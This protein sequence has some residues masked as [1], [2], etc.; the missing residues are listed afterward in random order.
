MIKA[1]LLT[2]TEWVLPGLD[3]VHLVTHP[4]AHSWLVPCPSHSKHLP[5]STWNS[6]AVQKTGPVT[7]SRSLVSA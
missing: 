4:P 1:E 7:V 6:L 5:F 3:S 2:L